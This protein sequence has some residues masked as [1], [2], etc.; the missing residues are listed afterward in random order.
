MEKK[1]LLRSM[2]I[3][4]AAAFLYPWSSF[5]ETIQFESG[6]R[7]EGKVIQKTTEKI[8]VDI[9]GGVMRTYDI[10]EVKNIDGRSIQ[11]YRPNVNSQV[12]EEN[13]LTAQEK[14]PFLRGKMYMDTQRYD[15]AIIEFNEAIALNPDDANAYF[16]RAIAYYLIKEDNK[17]WEDV[18]AAERLGHKI[19]YGIEQDYL[20][21]LK[22]DSG[23][24]K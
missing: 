19:E 6:R 9:G 12:Q 22:K 13:L 21:K 11:L 5:A 7:I 15:K 4:A 24:E 23:R 1:R 3:L 18:H 2:L 10:N 14:G 16:N 8:R 17:A 20:E